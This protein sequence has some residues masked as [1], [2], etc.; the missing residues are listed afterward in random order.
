MNTPFPVVLAQVSAGL[1][2][3]E[4]LGGVMLAEKF[5]TNPN[6]RHSDL[7]LLFMLAAI[8]ILL[9][10]VVWQLDRAFGR[11][12]REVMASADIS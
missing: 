9:E 12:N 1:L 8:V 10:V 7:P 4:S 3:A 5:D 2:A 6:T 11:A